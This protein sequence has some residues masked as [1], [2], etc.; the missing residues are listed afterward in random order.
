MKKLKID[1]D[2]IIKKVSKLNLTKKGV[3][4]FLQQY[5]S[6]FLGTENLEFFEFREYTSD[7]NPRIIDW[8]AS[9]RAGSLMAKQTLIE[10]EAEVIIIVDC[11]VSTLYGSIDKLKIEREL[12][13]ATGL[14]YVLVN[15]DIS[16]G[17]I[18]YNNKIQG[19]AASKTSRMQFEN[20]KK[21]LFKPEVF[22]EKSN[23]NVVTSLLTSIVKRETVSIFI[24][25]FMYLDLQQMEILK[26]L[27]LKCRI[28]GIMVRDIVDKTL[29]QGGYVSFS[30][31]ETGES[32]T[33]NTDQV[34]S[35][36][37]SITTQ[38]EN[39]VHATFMAAKSKLIKLYTNENFEVNFKK[40]LLEKN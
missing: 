8:R 9:M 1:I 18:L 14:A 33:I 21:I 12:E 28:L 20:I 5:E 31:P 4:G 38:Q 13:I 32:I 23:I 34:S 39:K 22:G 17:V 7:D 19:M 3:I 2:E 29:P 30:D 37:E 10:K 35:D 25:D 27:A 11:G 24:S 26:K 15:M 6:T 36:Y 16:T 40:M